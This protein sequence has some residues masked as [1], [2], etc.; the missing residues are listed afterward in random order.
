MS[1]VITTSSNILLLVTRR[2][3]ISMHYGFSG[4][5]QLYTEVLRAFKR[6][7]TEAT[8]RDCWFWGS[9][10][11]E[12]MCKDVRRQGVSRASCLVESGQ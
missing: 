10:E 4:V 9:K 7:A 6:D 5:F 12:G 2:I 1:A 11:V 3:Q 8:V